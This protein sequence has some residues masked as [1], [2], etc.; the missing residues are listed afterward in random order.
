MTQNAVLMLP[1]EDVNLQVLGSDI[2]EVKYLD[3]NQV[4]VVCPDRLALRTA[5]TV[6]VALGCGV[7]ST[8][9]PAPFPV[10]RF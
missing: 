8:D 3:A 7:V 1:V 9:L 4:Q 6:M 5:I 2:G 10:R